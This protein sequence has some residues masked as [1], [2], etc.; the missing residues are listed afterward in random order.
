VKALADRRVL[1]VGA[2]RGIGLA[3]GRACAEAGAKV[4]LS[5]RS[6]DKLNAA[7]ADL[8]DGS[9][10]VACEA[11]DDDSCRRAVAC[12]VDALGGL[13]ALVYSAGVSAFADVADVTR[14]ELLEMFETNVFGAH[15]ITA[16]ALPHLEV[17]EGHAIYLNSESAQYGPAPWRGIS[18]YIA[19]KR[20]LDS[21]VRSFQ[22]E[23][24][25]V[26]FTNY[27]VGA[28]V[29]E[30]GDEK[31]FQ[32][33]GDWLARGYIDIEHVLEPEDHGQAIVDI[34]SLSRRAVVDCIGLRP[35]R[36]PAQPPASL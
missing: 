32:F 20:A 27:V 31:A 16:A 26:A 13:D 8:G 28:T 14:A 30:F 1:V 23:H 29:T 17:A 2:S 22:V 35:R 5:A 6:V 12:A 25:N 3:I 19:S 36:G 10:A 24:P 7:V 4:A 34:L 11:R 18:G 9:V 15:S 21:L 33:A